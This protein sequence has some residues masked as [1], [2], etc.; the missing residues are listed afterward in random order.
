MGDKIYDEVGEDK[1]TELNDE[2]AGSDEFPKELIAPWPRPARSAFL[3]ET[4]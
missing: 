3:P 1:I 2:L 4:S